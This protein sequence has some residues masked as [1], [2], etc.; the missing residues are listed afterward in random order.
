MPV[1]P[2]DTY[3]FQPDSMTNIGGFVVTPD[4]DIGTC[5]SP[6]NMSSIGLPPLDSLS[7]DDMDRLGCVGGYNETPWSNNDVWGV[8]MTS[9]GD[10][11]NSCALDAMATCAVNRNVQPTGNSTPPC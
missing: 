1:C 7:Q 3:V 10:N 8:C 5:L 11:T 4:N 6:F 2:W 9:F